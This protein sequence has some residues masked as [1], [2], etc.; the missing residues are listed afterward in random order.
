MA[1][2]I[3]K[4]QLQ[5]L[6]SFHSQKDELLCELENYAQENKIPIID[7]LSAEFLKQLLIIHKPKNV[8]EIGMAIAYSTII[9]AKNTS[10]DTQIITLEK[11]KPNIKIAK[12]NIKK[13]GLKNKINIIE[14]DALETIPNLD[15]KFDFIFLDADKEDY[16]ELFNLALPKLDKGGVILIDNLLW[17]NNIATKR[18]SL[19]FKYS[20]YKIKEFNRVFMSCNE[21]I[22]NIY[23]IGDGLGV[24]IKL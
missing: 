14:G 16:I 20:A 9:I 23:P 4:I 21:L 12:D 17:H 22:K 19:E 13:S 24:G 10:D 6:K 11:S 7:W 15:K 2:I 3:N 8:L 5:Y 18:P 1:E